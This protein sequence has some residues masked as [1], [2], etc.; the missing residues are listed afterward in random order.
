MKN[1][2][3]LII[4]VLT[5][6]GHR[7]MTISSYHEVPIGTTEVQLKEKV[8]SPYATRTLKDG[9]VEYEYI[10]R[11]SMGSNTVEERHYFF[12]LD[13]GQVVNK[14]MKSISPP[15]YLENSYDMQTTT[16]NDNGPTE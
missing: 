14:Y 2:W 12:V 11:I 15:P 7:V 8:G 13:R 16:S 6:C 4:L 10:E 9:K 3:I 1:I 5:A